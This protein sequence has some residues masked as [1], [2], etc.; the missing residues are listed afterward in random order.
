MFARSIL[1]PRI[2][3]FNFCST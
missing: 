1:K 3:K 2:L